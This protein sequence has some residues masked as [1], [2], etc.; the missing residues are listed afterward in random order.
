MSGFGSFQTSTCLLGVVVELN[1]DAE[2]IVSVITK[3]GPPNGGP[4]LVCLP[5]FEIR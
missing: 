2:A 1:E 3:M 5:A 4:F